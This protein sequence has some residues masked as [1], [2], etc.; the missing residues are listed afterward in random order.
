MATK[1]NLVND[2]ILPNSVDTGAIEFDTLSGT[3]AVTV[4]DI[5]D[6]DAMTSDSATALATQQSIKAYV[7]SEISAIELLPG[8]EGPEGPPGQDGADGINSTVT[9]GTTAP[10]NPAVGDIW[11]DTN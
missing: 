4:T 2:D 3:G 5:L 10:S 7:D 8:P 6:E 9:V 11:V 1:I